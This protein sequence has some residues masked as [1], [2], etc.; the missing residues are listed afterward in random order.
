VIGRVKTAYYTVLK[1]EAM[2][3]L[4]RETEKR[5]QSYLESTKR[6]AEAGTQ[7]STDILRW[8][9]QLAADRGKIV[10][11]E[12]GLA[13]AR[14]ALNEVMGV[15][16]EEGYTLQPPQ[17]VAL[18]ASAKGEFVQESIV[19]Q[20]V[21]DQMSLTTHPGVLAM[22]G[23][24]KLQ[25]ANLKK[26]W[27]G[28]KPQ[29]NLA[30]SYSWEKNNTL[31]LDGG[32]S[33]WRVDHINVAD[34]GA[35]AGGLYDHGA[36]SGEG[37]GH[38]RTAG[39]DRRS[40]SDACDLSG[41]RCYS[42]AT[43]LISAILHPRKRPF[44]SRRVIVMVPWPGSTFEGSVRLGGTVSRMASSIVDSATSGFRRAFHVIRTPRSTSRRISA[45]APSMVWGLVFTTVNVPSREP[46][47]RQVGLWTVKMGKQVLGAGK[48]VVT[49]PPEMLIDCNY[50]GRPFR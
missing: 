36:A 42:G 39:R 32:C 5:T 24:V 7:T 35:C 18:M 16:L 12:N 25:Q 15:E 44:L 6:K 40:S 33:D 48:S 14:A 37:A 17:E 49:I 29:I 13:M 4:S 21:H 22:K 11:A 45:V 31:T 50:S 3:N 26:V 46:H 10:E 20:A 43:T 23:I 8:E 38:V 2:V 30:F 34:S 1:A 28:F 41:L 19:P 27:S 9:V 47:D